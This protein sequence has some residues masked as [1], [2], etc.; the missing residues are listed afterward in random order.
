MA[1]TTLISLLTFARR[2]LAHG[3]HVALG[4]G[5][6]LV[7]GAPARADDTEIFTSRLPQARPN[8]LFILDTSGSMNTTV[9][10]QNGFDPAQ[11]YSGSC[12]RNVVYWRMDI[13][14]DPDCNNGYDN[15][16][17][18]AQLVCDA[19]AQALQTRGIFNA[20]FAAQWDPATA[21]WVGLDAT[22]K[23]QPVECA[24]DAGRHGPNASSPEVF[25]ADTTQWT[26]D[27]T[28]QFLFD[29][30]FTDRDYVIYSGN[31]LNW[32]A[33]GSTGGQTRLQIM[34]DVASNLVQTVSGVNVGLMR[35]SNNGGSGE[36]AAEGGMVTFPITPIETAR[37][38]LEATIRGYTA[39]GFTP[40]SETL[41]EAYQYF[42]GGNVVFGANSVPMAS[43]S[44]SRVQPGGTTYLSPSAAQCQEN[45]IV[46]L[47]DGLPTRDNSADVEIERLTGTCDGTG[48]GRCLDDLAGYMRNTDL[49]DDSIVPG[50]Q[51]V[52]TYTVGFGPAVAGSAL[53]AETA[54]QGGG[55][56]FSASDT[57]SLTRTLTN[58]VTDIQTRGTTFSS[59]AVAVNSFN[60]TETLS[61]LYISVFEPG[62]SFHW[63]GNL[64]K[65]RLLDGEIADADGQLATDAQ[66]FF[67]DTAR[68]FWSASADGAEVREGGAADQLTATRNVYTFLGTQAQL[69]ANP[70]SDATDQQLGLD[71]P[72]APSRADLLNWARGADVRNSDNNPATAVRK[73]MGDP[74]HGRPAIVIYGG[75]ATDPEAVIYVPTNDG[76]LHAI[77]SRNGRELWAFIPVDQLRRL[78]GVFADTADSVKHY[79]LDGD[80][81]AFKTDENRNGIV[82]GNDRVQIV[83]GM[84]RGGSNYY[85]LNVTSKT[86]PRH[87][88]TI[89]PQQLP[90]VGQTWSTPAFARVA[91]G[92]ATQNA[93]KLVLIFGGGYDTTQDN[94][95][96]T[97]LYNTDTLG[98]RIYMVDAL[99]GNL[100]WYAGGPGG[101]DTPNLG[102]SDGAALSR[103]NNSIPAG[104]RVIDLDGDTFADR[105]YAA[106]TGGRVWRFDITFDADL[107]T[108]GVQTPDA[109]DLVTGGVIASLGNADATTHPIEST[110]RFYHTPNVAL[111]RRR[112]SEGYFAIS[113]GSGWRGHPLDERIRDRF[114]SLR[115][116]SPFNAISQADYNT[117][118]VIGD[119]DL[120]DIT[121]IIDPPPTIGAG[122]A[123][124]RLELR[125][126]GGFR[127]EKVLAESRT[128]DN[129]VFFPT[130]L[131]ASSSAT[132]G[133]VGSNRAYRVSVD[134]GRPLLDLNNDGLE[135]GDR[136]IDLAQRGGIAPE[137]SFL[138]PREDTSGGGNG[139][140]NGGGS[141][142]G[143]PRQPQLCSYGLQILTGFCGNAQTPVRTYWQ[144]TPRSPP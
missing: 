84:R 24:A 65:Y 48:P 60:R 137:I 122:A 115:D 126:P 96:G 27:P 127:G 38:A 58:I 89:G 124:W 130:Y 54:S 98:N 23:D 117:R 119:G 14:T 76:Y 5:L 77:D 25:A 33:S 8:I 13:G 28:Q 85:S 72:G 47:T 31:Y 71:Q 7:A 82:D 131:P 32:L 64:K 97:T 114:Y 43:I 91:V 12:E 1:S 113:L 68:S 87:R 42:S 83:F 136:Y 49:R 128:F 79:G 103:M 16:F 19:A 120:V 125:L 21:T 73:E 70:I 143:P 69:S 55:E 59:P 106:D 20:E 142:G 132:C 46:Y 133:P 52:T 50:E 78:P 93:D 62:D 40:L 17:Q 111:V 36:L 61:D 121:N 88:W 26:S 112:G 63:A 140:G 102:P 118:S 66:G 67:A 95:L 129:V 2:S 86:N 41:F 100:L 104:I 6:V 116:Y 35:Y 105:M 101:T 56:A 11:Q 34:Q 30:P 37:N 92:N 9:Q 22:V 107:G 139:G 144:Q 110:R 123:G 90:G 80:V 44:T 57:A 138:F 75:T 3:R 141:G 10:T 45:F 29:R 15:W 81:R 74:L 39:D 135:E 99:S 94:N 134:D 53:L 4:L 108:I 109:D 51:T 18:P